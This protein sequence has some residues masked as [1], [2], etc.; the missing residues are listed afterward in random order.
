VVGGRRSVPMEPEDSE[1]SY[2]EDKNGGGAFEDDY[3]CS[4]AHSGAVHS[5]PIDIFPVNRPPS[6]KN[7]ST[8]AQRGNKRR[9]GSVGAPSTSNDNGGGGGGGDG[10]DTEGGAGSTT[11][12][13]NP[14]SVKKEAVGERG[15]DLLDHRP[16]PDADELFSE[17]ENALSNFIRLHPQLSLDATSDRTMAAAA[18]LLGDC[19]VKTRELEQCSKTHDDKFLRRAKQEAGERPC[20][21]GEKC[22]CRWLAIFRFGEATENAFVCREFLLPS[23]LKT[24]NESG[25][26]PKTHS[27][28]L[29]CSRYFMSY[30]YTLARNSP[31]FKPTGSIALQAFGNTI[32]V[33]DVES[34]TLLY[35]NDVET[36]DGYSNH[37]MLYADER[38]A[39]LASSRGNLGTLLW[40]PVVRFKSSDYVFETD[41]VKNEAMLVQVNMSSTVHDKKQDFY[42]PSSPRAAATRA[43]FD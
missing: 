34:E 7:A 3:A 29:L 16:M 20:V 21:N 4:S 19:A 42:Q 15:N 27:K 39:D 11:K 26:L 1:S 24:F 8:S 43:R 36:E 38:W 14:P 23:Q 10:D 5:A 17:N 32:G 12:C 6:K 37:V 22:I 35:A 25:T 28:C 18:A 2:E 13:I 31:N 9:L 30:V 40:R 33:E 41:P